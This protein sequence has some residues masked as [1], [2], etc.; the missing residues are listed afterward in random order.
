M[1]IRNTSGNATATLNFNTTNL[2][3][4]IR[5]G[6]VNYEGF[7]WDD[8]ENNWKTSIGNANSNQGAIINASSHFKL[9]LSCSGTTT[10][11]SN[12]AIL[13]RAHQL[14]SL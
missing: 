1:V 2:R 11:T 13:Y 14:N 7:S 6:G 8:D 5:E 12:R 9:W 4:G 3:G 10:V